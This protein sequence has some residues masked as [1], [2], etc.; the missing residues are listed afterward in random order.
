MQQITMNNMSKPAAARLT[1]LQ[2]NPHQVCPGH[3]ATTSK[4]NQL[5]TTKETP[6][7]TTSYVST[8]GNSWQLWHAEPQQQQS[9]NTKHSLNPLYVL[10][11]RQLPQQPT[12][13]MSRDILLFI[14]LRIIKHKVRQLG[15]RG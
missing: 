9:T 14:R 6:P 3:P 4:G 5:S 12:H 8:P 2:L 7:L 1:A 10:Q 15:E 13:Y 11:Q